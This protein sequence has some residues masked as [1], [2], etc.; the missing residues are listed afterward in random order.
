MLWTI[1]RRFIDVFVNGDL[2]KSH[3][4]KH[5]PKQNTGDVYINSNSE[6]RRLYV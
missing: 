1:E 6:F 4:L 2:V 5:L 3:K